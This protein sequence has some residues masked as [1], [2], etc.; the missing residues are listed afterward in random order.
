ML[1]KS[2]LLS[3]LSTRLSEASPLSRSMMRIGKSFPRKILLPAHNYNRAAVEARGNFVSAGRSAG[4]EHRRWHG[5]RRECRLG[6]KGHAKFCASTTCSLCCIVKTS[7]DLSLFGKKTGWGR[8]VVFN[9][10]NI[11]KCNV[12]DHDTYR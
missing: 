2:A 5:T 4:N 12:I 10:W 9:L 8:Y 11:Q 1:G 6:D 3:R 7:F